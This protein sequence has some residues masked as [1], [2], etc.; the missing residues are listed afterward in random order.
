[1]LLTL[2]LYELRE[3]VKNL[4]SKNDDHSFTV[5]FYF[6]ET[7]EGCELLQLTS[8]Q[9][10]S[11]ARSGFYFAIAE[12]DSIE[13]LR[14]GA[15]QMIPIVHKVYSPAQYQCADELMKNRTELREWILST[16]D[17]LDEL[18][19]KQSGANSRLD[20]LFRIIEEKLLGTGLRKKE[21]L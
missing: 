15:A 2:S 8:D 1:M 11:T 14:W 5:K 17:R 10:W 18:A 19:R 4:L 21:S 13:I 20:W 16:E 12:K 6:S 7:K 9:F 3:Q